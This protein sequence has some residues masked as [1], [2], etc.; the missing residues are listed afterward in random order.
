MREE[1]LVPG[2]ELLESM[3]SVGYSF[4][5][6]VA[7]I[8]D[9]SIAA[10]ARHIDVLADTVSG[11]YVCFFDDGSGMDA[12]GARDALKLAGT[13][14]FVRGETD[15]G[16]FGLGLKTA[17]LSQGRRL[18]VL[19]KQGG[20]VTG[21]Q[22]DL[23]F[24]LRTGN[25]SIRVLEEADID[26]APQSELIRRG[27][28]GTLVIWESLDY[29]LASAHDVSGWMSS[30]LSELRNHL[31][32]V[33][34]RFLEGRDAL[35][36][37]VNG[38]KVSRIDPFLEDNR[39]TQVSPVENVTIEGHPVVVEAF[40]LPH[41]SDLT[42]SEGKR[43]DLGA[44]MREHQGFY[45]YRNRRLVSAGGWL[46]LAKQDELSKQTRVRVDIPPELDH[47]WQLD[48]K[49]SRVEPPQ[50]FRQR[51]R[52]I[53]DQVKIKSTRIHTFR[54]RQSEPTDFTFLWKVI[55]DRNGFRYEVNSDHPSVQAVR[56]ALPRGAAG[57]FENLL[58]DLATCFPAADV[59]AR[60]AGNQQREVP[61]LVE[62]AIAARLRALRDGG[63]IDTEP[64]RMSEA[65]GKIEPF[66]S[67]ENLRDL[68]TEVWKEV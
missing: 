24:V 65:L 61:L 57:T 54:G 49:K 66:N 6:A 12:S 39:R 23:D 25:W 32:L 68:V 59:Y 46:G 20:V 18:T 64:A 33:F 17:S 60:M 34:Q 67:V 29:L 53:I 41:A 10:G 44:R 7:D 4:N 3:R 42:T 58:A 11:S 2:V 28:H 38:I 51:F 37:S 30:R 26:A 15:L 9:N 62:T 50:A 45:V 31:G 16:R 21:L 1:P 52:Q 40:T 55:E 56:S 5:A 27:D 43:E 47:H 14:N 8:V 35:R 19:T 13:R 22:W 48:I 63:A 36:L